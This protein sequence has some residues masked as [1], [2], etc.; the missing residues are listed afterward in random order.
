MVVISIELEVEDDVYEKMKAQT[1]A[2]VECPDVPDNDDTVV[3]DGVGIINAIL[4]RALLTA[5]EEY[6]ELLCDEVTFDNDLIRWRRA[7]LV[8]KR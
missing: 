3:N 8:V 1:R 6:D 5:V 4:G 7:G 2:V